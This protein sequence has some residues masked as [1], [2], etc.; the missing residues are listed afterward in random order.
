MTHDLNQVQSVWSEVCQGL[1]LVTWV[2][3]WC[4]GEVRVQILLVAHLFQSCTINSTLILWMIA[5]IANI[6]KIPIM[7]S[8]VGFIC[9]WREMDN[10]FGVEI[11][12]T[13]RWEMSLKN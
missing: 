9:F 7:T 5:K 11:L 6:T 13:K 12:T 8:V 1:R 3:Q 2:Y 4:I 10:V